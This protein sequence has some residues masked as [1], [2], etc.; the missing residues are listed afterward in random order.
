MN[1]WIK[2]EAQFPANGREVICWNGTSAVMA[3]YFDG[4]GGGFQAQRYATIGDRIS[5]LYW[6]N[7]THWMPKPLKP[8]EL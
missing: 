5:V 8:E 1:N 4:I 7:V 3:I 6:N 2:L